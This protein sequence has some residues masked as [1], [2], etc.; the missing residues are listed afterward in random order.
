MY[1][2]VL[3]FRQLRKLSKLAYLVVGHKLKLAVLKG[4]V[5]CVAKRFSVFCTVFCSDG[6]A[7][8]SF[9]FSAFLF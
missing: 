5:L 7:V 8:V 9:S 2:I 4:A 1:E 6:L 3:F